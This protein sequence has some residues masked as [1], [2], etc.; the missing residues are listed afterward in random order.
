MS[1]PIS[2]KTL[3]IIL[4]VAAYA[5]SYAP[6]VH[7]PFEWLEAYFHEISHGL[8]AL[9]S[10][11]SVESIKLR[12]D[13][14]GV[15]FTRGGSRFFILFAGYTGAV[16]WGLLIYL[17]AKSLGKRANIIAILLLAMIGVS[18][19]LCARDTVTILIMVLMAV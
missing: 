12:T 7:V 14:S 18:T 3:F 4:M 9:L 13:G 2:D 8:A 6:V 1:K 15:C 19:A 5:V 10:G 11:G 17:S 16:L